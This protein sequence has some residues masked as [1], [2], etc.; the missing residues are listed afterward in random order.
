MTTSTLIRATRER[1]GLSQARLAALAGTSQPAVSRYE[2]GTASPSMATL[3]RLMAAMGAR[4]EVQVVDAA[5]TLDARTERMVKL[6][7]SRA[8]ILAAARAHGASNVRVFGSVARGED[9]A[10]SDVDL[11]VDMDV[12]SRGLFPLDDLRLELEGIL[13][14]PVDLVAEQILAPHVAANA[15]REAVAL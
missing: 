2:A 10:E 14:E 4:L 1:A 9:T 15:L 11:L 7:T 3:E 6:R 5:R 13:G 12:R 8:Q